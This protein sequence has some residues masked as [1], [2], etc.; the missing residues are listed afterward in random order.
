MTIKVCGAA[1]TVT[2]SSHLVT[3][4]DG[5]K[6]LLDCGLYQGRDPDFDDFNQEWSFD[7]TDIDVLVLSHSHIDHAGRIPKLVRDGFQGNIISTSATLD[8]CSI[9]LLDSGF[10]QEKDNEWVNKKR[11]R[12]GLPAMQPL[13]TVEDAQKAMKQFVGI[14][15]GRW[16]NIAQNVEVQF[17]DAGHILGSANITLK[18]K[19]KDGGYKH[20]GFTGDIG[21]PDRP[22][23]RDPQPM[24]PCDYLLC[25]STYGGQ[26]HQGMPS[27][28]AD[29]LRVVKET[30]VEKRGKLIIP[31]F[32]VGRTQEIVYMMDRLETAG[33]L[34]SVPVYVDSPLAV[35]A[36]DIFAMH[37]ECYDADILEYMRTDPNPFGFRK[38]NY[39][40]KVEESKAIN[41]SKEPCVIISASG[42]MQA[43]R[44]KHHINNNIENK[45]NTILVVGFCAA[46]TL[47]RRISDGA[48][49]VK[50][51]GK[52]KKVNAD[53]VTMG[54]FSAHG[55]Q[56]EMLDFLQCQEK[57]KL[58]RIFLVHGEIDR[59]TL[60]KKAILADGFKK[61]EIPEFDQEF[62]LE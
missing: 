16:F 34:P 48:D 45:N 37:P 43:G 57:S 55:D 3:T 18:I 54:S 6:I 38:L 46:N 22:I 10:I 53:V 24:P 52:L 62:E 7:P 61:V 32:S 20:V 44:V 30:C 14:G 56:Q 41:D 28:E 9:M 25:E 29:L 33:K 31:A 1:Q 23:L 39:V 35:D 59:Q 58:K 50:I 26:E 40:K 15:Y 47:G 36:T 42:M 49:E 2:G 8:L 27:D 5:V 17:N 13:Y 11:L 60:F 12:K 51:F 19:Q 21:R 4:G